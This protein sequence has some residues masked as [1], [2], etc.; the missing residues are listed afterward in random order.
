MSEESIDLIVDLEKPED[1]LL[2]D[3]V[4]LISKNEEKFKKEGQVALN[5]L[6]K[7]KGEKPKPFVY[8]INKETMTK[9]EEN[10]FF[11]PEKFLG[12]LDL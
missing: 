10:Y 7:K 1:Q 11:N 2:E 8:N 4:R 5:F 12:Q 3:L 9:A 6:V